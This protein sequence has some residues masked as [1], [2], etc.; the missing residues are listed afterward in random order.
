M[1]VKPALFVLTSHNTL[2]NSGKPTGF[3]FGEMSTPY[4]ILEDA[5]IPAVLA[6]IRGGAPHP[7]PSS[8]NENDRSKNPESVNRFL[9]DINAMNKLQNTR[10]IS[11]HNIEDYSGIYMPGGHGTMWDFPESFPLVKL[12]RRAYEEEKPIAAVC[13]GP[14]AFVNVEVGGRPVVQDRKINCFTDEEE[15]AVGKGGIVPFLLESRLRELGADFQKTGKWGAICVEDP[16][17]I[18]GQNPASVQ[19]VGE[20]LREHILAA[21]KE[22]A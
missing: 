14:A 3:H 8:V 6:S 10:P 11:E 4:Y 20:V 16:P 17:F 1:T 19:R 22:A 12:I 21:N 7:D 13:H 2:G 18:T 9:D 5:G 15:K